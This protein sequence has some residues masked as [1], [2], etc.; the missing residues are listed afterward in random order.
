[1][2]SLKNPLTRR[3]VLILLHAPS[4]IANKEHGSVFSRKAEDFDCKEAF[5][6]N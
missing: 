5:A 3:N 6:V 4:V 1:M 2:H